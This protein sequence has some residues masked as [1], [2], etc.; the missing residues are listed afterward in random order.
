[1]LPLLIVPDVLLKLHSIS[2]IKIVRFLLLFLLLILYVL[3]TGSVTVTPTGGTAPYQYALNNGPIQSSPTFSDLTEGSYIVTVYDA[4]GCTSVLDFVITESAP[5]TVDILEQTHETCYNARNGSV[6]LIT[7]GGVAPYA[8][9]WPATAGNQ[10]GQTAVNLAPGTYVV[11]VT[12]ANNCTT[13]QSVTILAAP[14]TIANAGND[15]IICETAG[16]IQIQ[17]ASATNYES[18]YWTTNGT[19]T[20]SNLFAMNPI[21][22]PSAADIATGSVILT[23]H[24]VPHAPCAEALDQM[25]LQIV[26]Q[27]QVTVADD[28]ICAGE[29]RACCKCTIWY[30]LYWTTSGTGTFTDPNQVNTVYIPSAA[31]IANGFVNLT[32]T[33]QQHLHV[34]LLVKWVIM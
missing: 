29:H 16:F 9:Q 11:T 24:A 3:G 13:T 33:A 4:V 20:F 27:P 34:L 22:Y 26:R 1:M 32:L 14:M 30:Y 23:L 25:V 15:R 7:S 2:L 17:G 19:G 18:L 31:D 12:D 10:T 8:Y 5:L 28:I 6:M 21:Y